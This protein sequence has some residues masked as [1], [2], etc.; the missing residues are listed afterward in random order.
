M[1]SVALRQLGL[2]SLKQIYRLD[3]F[4]LCS[5][6]Q[7]AGKR[8]IAERP[9]WDALLYRAA[10]LCPDLR[11][12]ELA[13]TADALAKSRH[14]DASFEDYLLREVRAKARRFLVRDSALLLNAMAKLSVRDE[15]LTRSLLPPLIRRISGRTRLDDLALLALS[16][17]RLGDP[18]RE[19]ICDQIVA[20]VMPRIGT[21]N[22]GHTLSLLACAFTV[23]PKSGE[24]GTSD[25]LFAG[26]EASALASD[27]QDG[28]VPDEQEESILNEEMVSDSGAAVQ[29]QH[30]AF[31]EALLE[32]CE[33][34]M[35]NFRSADLLHL[36]LAL[37]ALAR[38]GNAHVFPSRLIRRLQ[39]RM[40]NLYFEFMPAQFVR[41]L[42]VAAHLPE[43]DQQWM[44]KLL[45]EVAYRIRDITPASCLPVLRAIKR[46]GGHPR[47]HS[48]VSWRLA[49]EDAG[50]TL[51]AL[52]VCEVAEALRDLRPCLWESR[53]ALL[54]LLQGLQRRQQEPQPAVV[55]RLLSAYGELAVRDTHWF[56]LCTKLCVCDLGTLKPLKPLDDL[57][58]LEESTVADATLALARLN[59]PRLIDGAVLFSR[60]G[61][62]V[63]SPEH[64]A[65][66]LE[67]AGIFCLIE[68][69]PVDLLD[70]GRL[71]PLLA[72]WPDR[73]LAP[74][75]RLFPFTDTASV[76]CTSEVL[77]EMR[78]VAVR[79]A[80]PVQ[81][82]EFH[83]AVGRELASW[84]DIGLAS[85]VRVGPLRVPWAASLVGLAEYLRKN[86]LEPSAVPT[87]VTADGDEVELEDLADLT[88][89][90]SAIGDE[91]EDDLDESESRG[92][93]HAAASSGR[94][95]RR[96][97]RGDGSIAA[98]ASEVGAETRR[99][100]VE[101]DAT[102]EAAAE[103]PRTEAGAA[104]E[105]H[106]LVELLRDA[107]FYHASAS[108]RSDRQR[109]KRQLLSAQRFAE[110][111]LL[112][113]SGWRVCCIPEHLWSFAPDGDAEASHAN[114]QLVF[115][116]VA[117]LAEK[118]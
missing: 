73:G 112:R 69:R 56:R 6:L 115:K 30:L 94:R 78:A 17:A 45:D 22:D 110:I 16:F 42:D 11:P 10:L 76:T 57:E 60:A 41:F 106:I 49:G 44:A 117:G 80:A 5:A 21:V 74:A 88:V 86:P 15:L 27:C 62:V 81:Q 55:A 77:E 63:K 64:V 111:S 36:A 71:A 99:P 2:G 51:S 7:N 12:L 46:A 52:Q 79:Q 19:P 58:P 108:I 87:D 8:R 102:S 103:V 98:G 24:P 33:R 67:A 53:E 9:L 47:A 59:L 25:A 85:S 32:Q 35:W 40:D 14:R 18:C 109:S 37:S 70:P 43:L 97:R 72:A 26:E 38:S 50:K 89:A 95:S 116:L 68:R 118:G 4:E 100:S 92:P 1:S 31:V 82:D 105:T 23:P 113:R 29:L 96:G 114:R 107:D 65:A 90:A 3:T 91:S 101:A 61:A 28:K 20:A 104:P 54:S 13:L 39:R 83:L 48:A 84:P 34:H 75:L 66:V 93:A